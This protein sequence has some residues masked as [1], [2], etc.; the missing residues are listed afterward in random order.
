MELGTFNEVPSARKWQV[1]RISKKMP[2]TAKY[3]NVK[4]CIGTY[5]S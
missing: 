2:T 1:L 4:G 5:K 3:E